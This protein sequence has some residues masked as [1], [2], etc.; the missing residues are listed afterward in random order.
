MQLTVL[1]DLLQQCG[2]NSEGFNRE[3]GGRKQKD[4]WVELWEIIRGY[5][6]RRSREEWKQGEQRK[7]SS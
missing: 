5:S 6:E 1:T 3:K 7:V 4:R 2:E